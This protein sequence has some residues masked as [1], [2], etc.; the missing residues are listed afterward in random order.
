MTSSQIGLP[1]VT[2][3]VA[4]GL[5]IMPASWLPRTVRWPAMPGISALPP[6]EKP[7][8]KCGSIKPVSTLTSQAAISRLSQIS[9]P[10]LVTPAWTWVAG[11]KALF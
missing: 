6:P 7:A 1:W 11:S 9:W 8:K 3:Q 10:R 2:P 5:A 4:L